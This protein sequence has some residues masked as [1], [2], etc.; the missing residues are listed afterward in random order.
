MLAAGERLLKLQRENIDAAFAEYSRYL[1]LPAS[2]SD[3]DAMIED[4]PGQLEA[5][6]LRFA[7]TMQVYLEIITQAQIE[8]MRCLSDGLAA[9]DAL[10]RGGSRSIASRT[11]D[12]RHEATVIKFPDRRVAL[13]TVVDQLMGGGGTGLNV[14]AG[15][16]GHRAA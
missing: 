2:Q 11:P 3:A 13:A 14:K 5:S 10:P 12:R 1:C 8:M 6:A 15:S 4:W 9:S 16:K 7:N